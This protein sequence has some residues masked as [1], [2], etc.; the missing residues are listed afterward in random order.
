MTEDTDTKPYRPSRL[1]VAFVVF[2]LA[3]SALGFG[4]IIYTTGREYQLPP[5]APPAGAPEIAA[6]AHQINALLRL[7]LH[8]FLLFLAFL[9]GSYLIV[10]VGRSVVARRAERQR[11]RYMDVW[12]S[13]RL[14]QE[15]IDTAT[16][17]LDD[18][19]PP[20]PSAGDA[21]PDSPDP[22]DEPN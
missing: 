14:T 17:G 18:D 22:R 19:F 11:T 1:A 10:R 3:L 4:Y 13:Y 21:Q 6:K 16:T 8:S 2:G 12:S 7:L 9:L 5:A 20:A 15:E